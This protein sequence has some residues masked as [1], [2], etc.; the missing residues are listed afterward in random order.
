VTLDHDL[1]AG[2][3]IALE[4][5]A[6]AQAQEG[7]ITVGD[8][9]PVGDFE[10][11]TDATLSEMAA[12][13]IA[14]WTTGIANAGSSTAITGLSTTT[15]R[16]YFDCF[17][18][19][20]DEGTGT[21]KYSDGSAEITGQNFAKALRGLYAQGG[22]TD[23]V[24]TIWAWLLSGASNTT[25]EPAADLP[26]R[27]LYK[28]ATGEYD[29]TLALATELVASSASNSS[30]LYDWATMGLTAP[31]QSAQAGG[32]FTT[33]KETA[34]SLRRREYD[35]VNAQRFDRVSLRGKTGL[36]LQVYFTES[37]E[38]RTARVYDAQAAAIIGTAYR[39]APVIYA[40]KDH[41]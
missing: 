9:E 18:S 38:G 32:A 2:D 23:L 29:P 33:A 19:H 34:S 10:F 35:G 28:A 39:L 36:S 25:Y 31:L 30:N 14:F 8:D 6:A 24:S 17:I 21:W 12:E 26:N 37:V 40:T 15:A 16:E 5:I 7:D 27:T 20:T 11:R 13:A 3:L 4:F 22:Y 41:P 1:Y